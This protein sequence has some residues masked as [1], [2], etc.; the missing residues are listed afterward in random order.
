M[1]SSLYRPLG[2][3]TPDRKTT[4][5]SR[6]NATPIAANRLL[7]CLQRIDRQ[8]FIAQCEE[9]HLVDSEVLC[10][11]GDRID[12]AYFPIEGYISLITPIDYQAGFEV[13]MVGLEGM[14]GISISLGVDIAPQ[15]A[16]VQGAGSAL[17]LTTATF[18]RELGR[19]ASLHRVM[20]RYTYVLMSQMAQVGA[21]TRF[22]LLEARL[23]RLLLMAHDR[24]PGDTFHL[25]QEFLGYMLGMR[26]VGVTHAARALQN[27]ELITYAR[28]TITILDRGGLEAAACACYRIDRDAYTGVL[29]C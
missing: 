8:H 23:P 18:R 25:T 26:R 14:H 28:G 13:G 22:Q 10:E 9:V 3:P 2:S 29:G 19:S 15:R 11:R 17:R 24:T 7:N 6:A 1:E 12:Y 21:C 27:K 5:S 4:V 20:D 16:L